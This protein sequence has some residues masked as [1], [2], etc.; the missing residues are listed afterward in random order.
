MQCLR[1]ILGVSRLNRIRN[2]EVRRTT[3]TEKTIVDVIHDKRL[4]WSATC[5]GSHSIHGYTKHINKISLIQD[6]EEQLQKDGPI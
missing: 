2:I 5:A 1:S 4:K 3:G 6:L